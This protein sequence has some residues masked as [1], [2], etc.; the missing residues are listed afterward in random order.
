MGQGDPA[1]IV[2]MVGH[3]GLDWNVGMGL[4]FMERM[5]KNGKNNLSDFPIGAYQ[6]NDTRMD[7]LSVTQCCLRIALTLD[8]K[9]GYIPLLNDKPQVQAEQAQEVK[10][11]F[12]K[13]K[14]L[15]FLPVDSKPLSKDHTDRVKPPLY[16]TGINHPLPNTHHTQTLQSTHSNNLLLLNTQ[17]SYP[18]ADRIRRRLE[19]LE[20]KLKSAHVKRVMC[21]QAHTARLLWKGQIADDIEAMRDSLA[22]GHMQITPQGDSPA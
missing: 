13:C 19:E 2:Q 22:S 7:A 10:L 21:G 20:A 3:C 12:A 16:R 5:C 14:C 17:V 15:N 9:L 6:D 4:L 18:E 1:A 11:G 8:N